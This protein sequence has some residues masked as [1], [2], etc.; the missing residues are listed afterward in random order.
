MQQVYLECKPLTKLCVVTNQKTNNLH[1]HP[2]PTTMK[3]L[4]HIKA[5]IG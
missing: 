5:M 4:N 2:L 1:L 3:T